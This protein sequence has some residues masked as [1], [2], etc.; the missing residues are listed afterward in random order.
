[1]P[2]NSDHPEP[3]RWEHASVTNQTISMIQQFCS[4]FVLANC[5]ICHEVV[6]LSLSRN[7][8]VCIQ[9]DGKMAICAM[10]FY[11]SSC[12]NSQH[13]QKNSRDQDRRASAKSLRRRCCCS[14]RQR[15]VMPIPH[16]TI[17]TFCTLVEIDCANCRTHDHE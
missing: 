9:L 11:G 12:S 15:A 8:S 2:S 14:P 3:D 17:E 10:I 6:D 13:V 4:V 16:N 5:L 7:P 1:M